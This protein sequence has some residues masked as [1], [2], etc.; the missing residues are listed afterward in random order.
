MGIPYSKQI[1]HAFD[2]VTPLVAAGFEVLKTTKNIAILLAVIQLFTAVV[3]SLILCALLGLLLAADP[4][5]AAE[6]AAIVTPTMRWLAAW[7]LDYGA[8]ALR[9]A[10]ITVVLATAGLGVLVWQGS[11]VGTGADVDRELDEIDGQRPETE[12]GPGEDAEEKV[13]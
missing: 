8:F 11:L 1:H 5:L 3:L 12:E 6:R 4:D 2:Q 7:V 13:G 10:K 9:T